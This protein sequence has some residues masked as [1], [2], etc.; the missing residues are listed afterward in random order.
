[1]F[2]QALREIAD[3]KGGCAVEKVDA[4]VYVAA[5]RGLRQP[6]DGIAQD[7]C[8]MQRLRL[9][10]R[11]RDVAAAGEPGSEFIAGLCALGASELIGGV[12]SP[13]SASGVQVRAGSVLRRT[14][15]LLLKAL[16]VVFGTGLLRCGANTLR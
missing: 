11:D 5:V 1:M 13:G 2:M 4:G 16:G 6:G 7:A 3:R 12:L 9:C 10:A 15:L 14:E 8:E